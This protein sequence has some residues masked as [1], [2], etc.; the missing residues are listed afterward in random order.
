[1]N[2]LR[3]RLAASGAEEYVQHYFVYQ[4]RLGRE[5]VV[6]YLRKNNIPLQGSAVLEIGCAEGGVLCAFAEQGATRCYG[7]DIAEYRLDQA[8]LIARTL[9]LPCEYSSHNIVT[10]EPPAEFREAFDIVILRD[11]IEHLTDTSAALR[12]TMMCLRPGGVLL[13]TFPPYYSPYGGHQHTLNNTA[14]KLPFVHALPGVMFGMILHGGRPPDIEEVQQLRGIRLTIGKMRRAIR[15]A[16]LEI[17]R[18]DIYLLRP[19]FKMKF[20]LPTVRMN[21]FRH[22]PL[23]REIAST[24][25]TYLL[26]K[27]LR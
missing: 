18:E 27:P 17:L 5:A 22:I 13:I 4:Y 19:V 6:P 1:M 2:E 25:A 7:T 11:V 10:Q 9:N 23:L 16:G 8:R 21:I 20:G 3:A 24:E 26:R 14:G 15:A 12:H